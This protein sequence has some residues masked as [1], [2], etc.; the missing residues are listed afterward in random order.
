MQ[1]QIDA[2][3]AELRD[4]TGALD[5]RLASGPFDQLTV[6]PKKTGITVQLVALAWTPRWE[7]D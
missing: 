6:A 7:I 3:E 4:E 5:T 2:I 1:Q